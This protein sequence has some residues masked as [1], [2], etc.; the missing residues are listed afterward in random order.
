MLAGVVQFEDNTSA[1]LDRI[2]REVT[3]RKTHLRAVGPLD[4]DEVRRFKA[5]VIGSRSRDEWYPHYLKWRQVMEYHGYRWFTP[6]ELDATYGP[7]L[8]IPSRDGQTV[9]S[10]VM[11]KIATGQDP[12]GLVNR[13]EL[14]AHDVPQ[15][16]RVNPRPDTHSTEDLIS[17]FGDSPATFDEWCRDHTR[18]WQAQQA[19]IVIPSGV[20]LT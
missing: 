19:G 16:R 7:Q 5:D 3:G 20:K 15:W 9:Y 8:V 11:W 14:R 1:K 12:S 18:R 4:P 10:E 2:A 17:L 13:R 6:E